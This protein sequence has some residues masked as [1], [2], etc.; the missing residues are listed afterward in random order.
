MLN[1]A[2]QQAVLWT[3]CKPDRPSPEAIGFWRVRTVCQPPDL[4]SLA[5][6]TTTE[7]QS[8]SL[9]SVVE[10]VIAHQSAFA[11]PPSLDR[12]ELTPDCDAPAAGDLGRN[13][14]RERSARIHA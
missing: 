13:C 10:L 14:L 4:M 8:E 7:R 11:A 3:I 1:M 6:I 12:A 2:S 5:S 9:A